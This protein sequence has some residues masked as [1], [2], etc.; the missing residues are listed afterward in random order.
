MSQSKP[1]SVLRW[2]IALAALGGMLFLLMERAPDSQPASD[3]PAVAQAPDDGPADTATEVFGSPL[4]ALSS[5]EELDLDTP[6]A[7]RG[8]DLQHWQT[9]QGTPVYFMHA[10]ELPM[11]DI[12]LLYAAGASRDGE[13]PGLAMFTNAMLNEGTGSLDAGDIAAG[14]ERLG[15]QFGNSSHRDMG[16]ISLRTLTA[17]DKLDPALTLFAQILSKPS[18]PEASLERIRE[19]L[20]AGLRYARQRPGSQASEALW[21]TLYPDHPYGIPPDGTEDSLKAIS[22]DDLQRFQQTYY[23]AGNA[24]IALV[25]DIDRARAEQLAQHLADAMPQGPAAEPTPP[26]EKIAASSQH[27]D[28]ASS[29]THVLVAQQGMSRTDPDYAALYLGN[30]ILGGS[31]FGSRLVEEVREKRGLSY[32]VGSNFSAMQAPGPFVISLQT[33][34]DQAEQALEVVNQTL[35]RFISEGPTDAEVNRAKQ[36]LLGEFPL[37][38]ASNSAI[39]AQLAAI[40]FYNLPLNHMQLFL[41]RVQALTAT[42][43]REAFARHLPASERVVIT[44]G[45]PQPPAEPEDNADQPSAAAE[46]EPSA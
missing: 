12:Q 46:Q 33:R 22:R 21:S 16:L 14:F 25:G 26:A 5:L 42:D 31:G 28:F 3:T 41:D 19:Q 38:T 24:V 39:V 20:L 44:V 9:R 4:P 17:A 27:I 36:Q 18:F 23:S 30:Q 13:L 10:G 43:I 8:L 11:L 35:D 40:G 37:S 45:P 29:Q 34:S 2:L 15:A 6:P 7:R 32:S 1:F